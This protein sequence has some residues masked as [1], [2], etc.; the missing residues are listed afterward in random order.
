MGTDYCETRVA[1][2]RDRN[3]YREIVTNLDFIN[4]KPNGEL[5]TPNSIKVLSRIARNELGL[6]F[7]FHNLRHTYASELAIKGV[8]ILAVKARLGH[9]SVE[10]TTQYYPYVSFLAGKDVIDV[11]DKGGRNND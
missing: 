7:K 10:T 1:D 8:S 2:C 6:N 4:I 9:T 3:K 11:V 5:L